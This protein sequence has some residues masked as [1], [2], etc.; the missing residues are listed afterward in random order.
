MA[1][2]QI[3]EHVWRLLRP[4]GVLV[5]SAC[6]TEPE[7]SI[8][9]ISRF[10][11]AHPDFYHEASTP[12]LPPLGPSLVNQDGDLLTMGTPYPMDGFFA[13][14]LRKEETL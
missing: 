1:Q 4:G 3:L 14:R 2:N 10:C 11:R 7:E 9:V 6:S 8:Q 5:Y 12:W 13:A